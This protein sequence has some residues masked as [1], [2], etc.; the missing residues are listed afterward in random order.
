LNPLTR[1][2]SPTNRK[3]SM[4]HTFIS[5]LLAACLLSAFVPAHSYTYQ[6]TT[7]SNLKRWPSNTIT[8]ALST[9]LSSPGPN[10]KPGTDVVGTVRR[11]LQR[12]AEAANVQFV[13]DQDPNHRNLQ[14]VSTPDPT[15]GRG[16]GVRLI[17]IA[18]TPENRNVF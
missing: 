2:K 12:W 4:R 15:T 10:I 18:D 13:E 8:I 3:V 9:S 14:S 11:A 6:Y 1:N 17:T 16:D 7:N 5:L